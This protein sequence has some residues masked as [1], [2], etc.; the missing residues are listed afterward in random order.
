MEPVAA[1]D[2]VAF[3]RL[4]CAA[5][6][7]SH[8]RRGRG[9]VVELDILRF[10]N[11]ASAVALPDPVQFL[12]DRRL[13]VRP[14]RPAGVRLGVDEKRLAVLPD[15]EAAVMRMAFAVHPLAGARIAQ[16]LDRAEF[17]HAGADAFQHIRFRLPLD[18]DAVDSMPMQQMGEEQ[19]GRAA[20]DDRDLSPAH[21]CPPPGRGEAQPDAR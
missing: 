8:L 11:D 16:N 2:E 7:V 19:A 9:Q 4:G 1:G 12:G 17:E 18:D 14:H 20:A 10:F 13:P 3:E 21:A 5:L 6:L 15:D